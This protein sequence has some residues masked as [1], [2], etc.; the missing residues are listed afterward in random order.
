MAQEA[1]LQRR[2]IAFAK[3]Q[4]VDVIRL[5]FAPGAAAGWPDV[6]FLI[7]GGRPL[8]IEFKAAGKKPTPLQAFRHGQLKAAGYDVYVHDDYDAACRCITQALAGARVSAA[9]KRISA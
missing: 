5:V 6:L 9:G 8:F 1:T 4:D 2:V 3:K 7:P